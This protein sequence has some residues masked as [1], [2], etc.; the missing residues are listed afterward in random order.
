MPPFR[1]G[2]GVLGQNLTITK[3]KK[4]QFRARFT[5]ELIELI[6]TCLGEKRDI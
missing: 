5:K 4:N 2:Y 1:I 3:L 6:N